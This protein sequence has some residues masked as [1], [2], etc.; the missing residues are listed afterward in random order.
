MRYLKEFKGS[1]KGIPQLMGV[2]ASPLNER[3]VNDLVFIQISR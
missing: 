2:R 1:H 3:D